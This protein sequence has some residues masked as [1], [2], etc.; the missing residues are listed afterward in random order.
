MAKEIFD[1]IVVGGG[2]S[3]LMTAITAAKYGCRILILEQKSECGKKINATGNGKCNFTNR[4]W[5]KAY[6]RG[7]RPEL[8]MQVLAEFPLEETLSFFH[9]IGIYPKE[10][11]GYFYP[12]SE[13]ASSVTKA[14]VSAAKRYGCEILCEKKVTKISKTLSGV[15]QVFCGKEI[16]N[17]KSV[18]LSAGGMASPVH[19]SDGSG[20]ELAKELGHHL[21]RPVPAIVQ[22][23]AEGAFFKTLAGVRTDG[24]ITL[25]ISPEDK[26]SCERYEE[27]GELL[28][29]AYGVSGIPVMQVSRYASVALAKGKKVEAE[30]DFMQVLDDTQLEKE[31]TDRF[32]RLSGQT[33]EEALAGLCNT[34]LNY[35]LCNLS[36]IEPTKDSSKVTN[37][38][39]RRLAKLYKHFKIRIT[40][41]NGFE[42]AQ[43]C[44]GGVLLEELSA[45]LE[46]KFVPG[47]YFTGEITDVDGTCGGYNLQWAWSSGFVA[48][49]DIGEKYASD[50]TAKASV[51]A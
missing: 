28:L 12:Q 29:A 25:L 41:T 11:N 20:F 2:A 47:L 13:Q 34:K 39:I 35:V 36:K 6:F 4:D 46:S 33:A 15:F 22:L 14:L 50:T 37:E 45:K 8:A 5:K 26:D 3:G 17:A 43:A 51:K 49:K 38:E 27:A 24:K 30:L 21:V 44:A 40:D 18:V 42:N 9:A 19:G 7:N 32:H 10:R 23:K 48:G 31:L 1:A 16:Y